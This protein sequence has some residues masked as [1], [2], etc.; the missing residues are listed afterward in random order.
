MS[1]L[2]QTLVKD[3]PPYLDMIDH[4]PT[5][6]PEVVK[7]RIFDRINNYNGGNKNECI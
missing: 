5:E 1:K 4:K 2:S 3:M 7:A 6:D